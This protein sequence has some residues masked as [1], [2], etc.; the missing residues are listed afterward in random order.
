MEHYEDRA[1]YR[2]NAIDL[3]SSLVDS[4]K[5]RKIPVAVAGF[6]ETEVNKTLYC[7]SCGA[8]GHAKKDCLSKQR[9]AH[10]LSGPKR[11]PILLLK[12]QQRKLVKKFRSSLSVSTVGGTITL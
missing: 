3:V 1:L 4:N 10:T 5:S 6:A 2:D 8:S 7:W 9:K 12:I 11:K